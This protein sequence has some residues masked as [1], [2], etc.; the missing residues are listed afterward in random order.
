MTENDTEKININVTQKQECFSGN[1]AFLSVGEI[2]GPGMQR[3]IFEDTTEN[4]NKV[5]L[6]LLAA[7]GA[8]DV[9]IRTRGENCDRVIS[10]TIPAN[11]IRT[12]QVEDFKSLEVANNSGANV[13]FVF[14]IFKHFCICCNDEGC[15][16]KNCKNECTN[17][18]YN[19]CDKKD[20]GKAQCFVGNDPAF[21]LGQT[22]P[23]NTI[24]R[25]LFENFTKNHIKIGFTVSSSEP[26]LITIRYR[27]DKDCNR[28]ITISIPAN[29][30]R[31]FQIED[32]KSVEVS[33][34]SGA[35]AGVGIVFQNTICI[36][37]KD[38][39]H[40]KCRVDENKCICE[41]A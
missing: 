25:P 8:L 2:I 18:E 7:G 29:G 6:N 9:K 5:M 16:E 31:A 12:F 38:R 3:T 1:H 17:D 32:Y 19:E 40:K 24:N 39:K 26:I 30:T 41:H 13:L 11:S 23:N 21:A 15:C 36:C 20:T 33:N 14:N 22:V 4:H 34:S 35:N 28:P 37:C 10:A 27:E